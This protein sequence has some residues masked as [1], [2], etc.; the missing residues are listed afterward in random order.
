MLYVFNSVFTY[1]IIDFLLFGLV[2]ISIKIL[3]INVMQVAIE[4][5]MINRNR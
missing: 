3:L 1:F 5:I 2:G 4:R